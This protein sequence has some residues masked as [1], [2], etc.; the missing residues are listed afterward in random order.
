MQSSVLCS[1]IKCRNVTL[2]H[3][4]CRFQ[5]SLI[6]SYFHIG[7][8]FDSASPMTCQHVSLKCRWGSSIFALAEFCCCRSKNRAV[9]LCQRSTNM[10]PMRKKVI[11]LKH[12]KL[13]VD[14]K[15]A[16]HTATDIHY[17]IAVAVCKIPRISKV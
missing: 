16:K 15:A 14:T 1:S 7:S 3:I 8:L 6:Y 17:E 5:L 11:S 10:Q 2:S 12:V 9:R 4:F 13:R